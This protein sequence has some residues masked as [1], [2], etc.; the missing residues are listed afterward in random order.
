VAGLAAT[1][2]FAARGHKAICVDRAPAEAGMRDTRTTAFLKPAV[3]VLEDAGV[4]PLLSGETAALN[5]MRLID[6]GGVENAVREIA[7]FASDEIGEPPFSWNVPNAAMRRALNERIAQLETAELRA[8]T[9]LDDLV[10]RRDVALARLSD[11]TT[12]KAKLIIGADGRN[13]TIRDLAGIDARRWDY[14][15]KAL[16]F[17]VGTEEPHFGVST[18]IH[19]TGGPFTLV[20]M[21]DGEEGPRASVVWMERAGE[22]ER[23]AALPVP[24]FEEALNDRALGVHGRLKLISG[25]A[26]WPIISLIADR[27]T[28][29][30][31]ALIAES[32]HVVPPIGAQGLNMS[33][34]DIEALMKAVAAGGGDPG[35]DGVL[36]A[37]QRRWPELAARVSGV[38]MLNRAALTEVQPLRDLRLVGLT[39]LTQLR[40]AK[41]LAMRLGMGAR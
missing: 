3:A 2:A 9:A 40:P 13:S 22:A 28:A 7:D 35:A 36:S 37:Y 5:V 33:L 1:A 18:E 27:L 17:T 31:T 6:A 26:A 39:A 20:P 29:P 30:R 19:R 14:G 4:W 21:P 41:H 38:D 16:V 25:R 8:E 32:A 10:V 12:A 24:E 34:G 15:Q 23:L 11:G